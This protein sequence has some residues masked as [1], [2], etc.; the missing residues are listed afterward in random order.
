M[1]ALKFSRLF[2]LMAVLLLPLAA[3]CSGE[4]RQEAEMPDGRGEDETHKEAEVEYADTAGTKVIFKAEREDFYDFPFPADHRRTEDGHVDLTDFPPIASLVSD[5]TNLIANEVQGFSTNGA[6]YM[7]FDGPL[8]NAS[9]PTPEQS[10][11]PASVIRLL[12]IDPESE[13]YGEQIPLMSTIFT[14]ENAAY[15]PANLLA[16]MPYPGFPLDAKTTYALIVLRSFGD[17]KGQDL[18]VPALLKKALN[19]A[20]STD[21]KEQIII[22]TMAPL[23]K[24]I[25]DTKEL[26]T[27]DIAAATVF[28]TQDP[29]Q[30]LIAI[31]KFI[32]E[33]PAPV[34]QGY[35]F[36]RN[37]TNYYTVDA[38]Y[39]A[40]NYQQGTKPYMASGGGFAFDESGQPV[41]ADEHEFMLVRFSVPNDAS[42]MPEKGWPLVMIAHGTGG[43]YNNYEWDGEL[44]RP[45]ILATYGMAAIGIS[46]PLHYERGCKDADTDTDISKC[47]LDDTTLE[48]AAFNVLNPSSGRT[49]FRQ[50]AADT[51]QLVKMLI[52]N[53]PVIPASIAPNGVEARFDTSNLLF[54]GHS[55]G[56]I[57]GAIA[58]GVEHRVKAALHSGAGGL[59]IGTIAHSPTYKAL[60][61][62]FMYLEE[63]EELTLLHPAMMIVQ[64]AAD[65]TD[66]INYAPYYLLKAAPGEGLNTLFTIGKYDSDTPYQTNNYLTVAAGLPVVG[67]E[68]WEVMG[69]KL[70]KMTPDTGM[71]SQNCETPDGRL[72]T[73]GSRQY[74]EEDDEKGCQYASSSMREDMCGHFVVFDKSDAAHMYGE[75]FY[76][77]LK[78]G[79]A[80]INPLWTEETSLLNDAASE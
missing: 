15:M 40:P 17:A 27:D 75:F 77:Y 14:N 46:Q 41:I 31:H 35:K 68:R 66:P 22:K 59:L 70:K 79:K 78:D 12:N 57:S 60:A 49:S 47:A 8:N 80:I 67:P 19:G 10:Q 26:L 39:Y 33:R 3:A 62:S 32:N 5:Y 63:G 1:K 74:A 53:P 18:G 45:R 16:A 71:V 72:F 25:K 21:A 30:E 64:T 23:A 34:I 56:G 48:L 42:K 76:S 13:N 51:F 29:R 61:E 44:T 2:L 73:C 36:L 43:S 28:T 7:H 9:L 58:L 11:E 20:A 69:R 50:S 6:I 37:K 4:K 38:Y 55:H 52:D 54:H 24:Y 65:V